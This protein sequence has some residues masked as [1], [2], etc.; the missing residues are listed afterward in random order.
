MYQLEQYILIDGK[1]AIV[2]M[3]LFSCILHKY[4]AKKIFWTVK[5][6]FEGCVRAQD[7][8]IT[9]ERFFVRLVVEIIILGVQRLY[10][11]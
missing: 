9:N 5:K 4:G 3:Y 7:L 1:F 10:L 8:N 6:W 11:A 2:K